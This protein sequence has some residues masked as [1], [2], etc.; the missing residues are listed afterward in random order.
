MHVSRNMKIA[1][2]LLQGGVKAGLLLSEIAS[3]LCRE[4]LDIPSTLES[5]CEIALADKTER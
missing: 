2:R 5:Y 4:N 1:G 3:I